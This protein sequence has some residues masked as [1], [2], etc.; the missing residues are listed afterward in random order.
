MKAYVGAPLSHWREARK[1]METLRVEGHEV[2][3]DWTIGA[4]A[5]FQGDLS[6]RPADIAKKCIEGVKEADF[7]FFLP[8]IDVPMQGT[9][10]EIGAALALEKPVIV[11]MPQLHCHP[12][13][14]LSVAAWMQNRGAFLQH[15]LCFISA[16]FADCLKQIPVIFHQVHPSGFK[17]GDH[18]VVMAA[19]NPWYG[20]I[21]AFDSTFWDHPRAAIKAGCTTSWIDVRN[22]EK[23][24]E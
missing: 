21:K 18:V 5:F 15:P 24:K 16:N 17:V 7:A 9:W 23:V 13:E 4:E 14:C 10:V 19:I 2:T 11:Y 20:I 22:L 3:H 8:L 12:N 1:T 6:E